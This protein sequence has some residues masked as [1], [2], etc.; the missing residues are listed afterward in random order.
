MA[1]LEWRSYLDWSGDP[2]G[3]QEIRDKVDVHLVNQERFN[4]PER[5]IAKIF[6][7]RWMYWGP[8]YSYANDPDFMPTSDKE[9]FWQNVIDVANEKYKVL[10]QFQKD[11]VD[12]AQRGNIIQIPTGRQWKFEL[13]EKKRGWEWPVREI[14]NW[15]NQGYAAD[16]MVILRVSVR[17]RL[18][19]LPEYHEKKVLL[20]NT[21]HDDIQLDCANDKDLIK[22][23][24]GILQKACADVPVNFERIYR[25]PF[26]VPLA[27]EVSVGHNLRDTELLEI[28][29]DKN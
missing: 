17:N 10:F 15:P 13:V 9:S 21:V 26:R 8:A 11:L 27:G 20:F 12:R 4:L 1:Q 6:L 14:V 28:F 7:F 25:K 16:L 19:Q 23:V 3:I 24:G 29:L 5:V 22:A 18:L 2:V